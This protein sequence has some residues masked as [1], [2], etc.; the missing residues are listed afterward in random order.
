MKKHI[1]IRFLFALIPLGFFAS[2]ILTKSESGNNFVG[3]DTI[4][5]ILGFASLTVWS[6]W[7]FVEMLM[8]FSRKRKK[9]A[10]ANVG[11]LILVF[12]GVLA[13]IYIK[14]EVSMKHSI[15][16]DKEIIELQRQMDL[17]SEVIIEE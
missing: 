10:L 14:N 6:I 4:P 5:I 9:F 17:D 7:I 15:K 1:L 12:A 2:T 8:L 11:L 3:S 13:E 16:R